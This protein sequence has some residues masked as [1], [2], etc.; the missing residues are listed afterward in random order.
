MKQVNPSHVPLFNI[1]IQYLAKRDLY[2]L[3]KKELLSTFRIPQVDL[4]ILLG[5][6]SLYVA[7][8][9]AKAYK[10]GLAKELMICG[11]IGHSTQYLVDNVQKHPLYHTIPVTDRS[12]ADILK[13]IF[14]R[15][16]NI[17]ANEI[18]I[19]NQSTNCGA[20]ALEASKQ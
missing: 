17:N 7:E 1:L 8:Q 9:A 19:E 13:D 15:F 16:W 14:I 20:N 2:T 18:I 4:L 6:S 11:G 5:N 10:S 12:E 3:S